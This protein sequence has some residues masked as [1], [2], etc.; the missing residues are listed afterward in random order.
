[1][2]SFVQWRS[3]VNAPGFLSTV[4]FTLILLI[5]CTPI[6]KMAQVPEQNPTRIKSSTII[7]KSK[8]VTAIKTN[9]PL[10][11]FNW[12]S[13]LDKDTL[14]TTNDRIKIQIQITSENKLVKDQ[15]TVLINGLEIGNK[16]G[17]VS[18]APGAEY[19]GQIFTT[20][21]PVQMGKNEI[22]VM[23]TLNS[24]LKYVSEQSLIRDVNKI[25][26]KHKS[27]PGPTKVIWTNP[28]LT[29]IPPNE[30]YTTKLQDLDIELRIIS[31]EKINLSQIKIYQNRLALIPSKNTKIQDLG[32]GSYALKDRITLS[33]KFSVNEILVRVDQGDVNTESQ[34]FRV[35]YAP[36]R[37]NLYL[38][39]IGTKT[40]LRYSTKDARDFAMAYEKQRFKALNYF[41]SIMI[42]TL[43]GPQATTQ[44]IRV[45]IESI[46]AKINVGTLSE[47]D[48]VFLFF[49]SHGFVDENKDFRI[50]GDDFD[51]LSKSSTSV[52][53]NSEILGPLQKLSCKKIIFIDACQS[54]GAKASN[55]DVIQAIHTLK[56]APKGLTILTSSGESEES[57]E[58]IKW[59]NG[60]FTETLIDGLENGKADI[61]KNGIITINEITDYV[62]REV[63]RIVMEVKKVKQTPLLNRN[64]LGDISIYIYK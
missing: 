5:A 41:N 56:N 45:A 15:I 29:V 17:E 27:A 31:N 13:P 11:T 9:Q 32:D 23:V 50:Q 4:L 12:I 16:A 18:L 44:K 46:Q 28:N 62:K 47:D 1:M 61:N 3:W 6:P 49:S 34:K 30:M 58:D 25:L 53:Y 7:I 21:I 38:L 51:P 2:K 60:A 52:S 48:I 54:G 19:K 40:N 24:D 8:P 36:V 39:S 64:E 22:Q 63:P 37:P 43:I 57:H 26:V 14:R 33:D 59:R 35:N 42:D 10:V 20:L 55:Q